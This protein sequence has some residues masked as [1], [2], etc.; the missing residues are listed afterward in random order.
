MII[1]L[2]CK[3]THTVIKLPHAIS[4][5]R[6]HKMKPVIFPINNSIIRICILWNTIAFR[7]GNNISHLQ[8]SFLVLW[9]NGWFDTWWQLTKLLLAGWESAL[10]VNRSPTWNWKVVHVFSSFLVG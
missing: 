9:R 6:I 7:Y 5:P 3:Q 8:Q 1:R 4:N 2:C 10:F